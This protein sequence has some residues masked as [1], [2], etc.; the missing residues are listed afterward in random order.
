MVVVAVVMIAMNVCG[1]FMSSGKFTLAHNGK[2]ANNTHS[3]YI[4]VRICALYALYLP[5]T[6]DFEFVDSPNFQRNSIDIC[7][8]NSDHHRDRLMFISSIAHYFACVQLQMDENAIHCCEEKN[9]IF[10]CVYEIKKSTQ[11][12]MAPQALWKIIYSI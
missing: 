10:I 1:L 8:N 7:T 5:L 3:M 12:Q 4:C 9:G 6:I 11:Y 2:T